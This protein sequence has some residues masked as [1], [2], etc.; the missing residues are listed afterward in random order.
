MYPITDNVTDNINTII[1]DR[2]SPSSA[3]G[4]YI[5]YLT[6]CASGRQGQAKEDA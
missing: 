1:G 4:V 3:E 6:V 5:N 2:M